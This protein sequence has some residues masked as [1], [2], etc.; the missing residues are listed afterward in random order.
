M[1]YLK[2]F[3]NHNQYY[4]EISEGEFE[5]STGFDIEYGEGT[6]DPSF[7]RRNWID[8][9]IEE[10]N[11]I[12]EL[13][14]D[15][16]IINEY[17]FDYPDLFH[18]DETG[19]MIVNHSSPNFVPEEDAHNWRGTIFIIIKLKDEWFYISNWDESKKYK[20]DQFTGLLEYIKDK[21]TGY[22]VENKTY[23]KVDNDFAVTNV[24][25][26]NWDSFNKNDIDVIKNNFKNI[27]YVTQF[28]EE[29]NEMYI[30]ICESDILINKI[31]IYKFKD[32]WFLL[33]DSRGT[34]HYWCDQIDG[35]IDCLNKI[36]YN[37][38]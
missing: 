30:N 4:Q 17:Y 5:E 29:K 35:V 24:D 10:L 19:A 12:K 13:L 32:E 36:I 1:K 34:N 26:D 23:T 38:K 22:V 6:W 33:S 20:C 31:A 25:F 27:T 37:K 15:D 9:T 11:S 18:R 3:E 7:I 21:F 8:F 14:P 2:L 28:N 16:N